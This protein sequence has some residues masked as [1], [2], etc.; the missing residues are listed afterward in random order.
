MERFILQRPKAIADRNKRLEAKN[1]EK[2]EVPAKRQKK[3]NGDFVSTQAGP[4]SSESKKSRE[5]SRKE[6]LAR[7]QMKTKMYE[8]EKK[9][10]SQENISPQQNHDEFFKSLISTNERASAEPAESALEHTT[11][12]IIR[13]TT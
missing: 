4:K 10:K 7:L 5:L 3:L 1:E 6:R 8:A 2:E 12:S 11:A 9:R 13:S